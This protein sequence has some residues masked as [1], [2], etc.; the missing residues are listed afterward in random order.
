MRV[1]EM[2]VSEFWGN[3]QKAI[4]MNCWVDGEREL[5]G[6]DRIERQETKKVA[7]KHLN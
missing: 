6:Q 3:S 5:A 7:K 2:A 4:W 1:N